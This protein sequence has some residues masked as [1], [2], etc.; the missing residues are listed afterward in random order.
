MLIRLKTL[1]LVIKMFGPLETKDLAQIA[2]VV[3]LAVIFL[4]FNRR[5][6]TMTSLIQHTESMITDNNVD[7]H[8]GKFEAFGE[9]CMR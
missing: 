7:Q 6:A 1:T 8:A 5:L 4:Y 9:Y 3:G 2:Y